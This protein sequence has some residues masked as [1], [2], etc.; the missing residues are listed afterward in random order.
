M[1]S[2]DEINNFYFNLLRNKQKSI[3]SFLNLTNN[4]Y[5]KILDLITK[6]NMQSIFLEF[7]KENDCTNIYK[8]DTISILQNQSKLLTIRNM[9]LISLGRK[10]ADLMNKKSINYAFLKGFRLTKVYPSKSIRTIRDLDILVD[11]DQIDMATKAL[12][13][14]GLKFHKDREFIS[15]MEYL[16]EFYDIPPLYDH[17]GNAIEIHYKIQNEEKSTKCKFAERILSS[18]EMVNFNEVKISCS[19]L[20]MTYAHILYQTF[21]KDWISTGHFFIYDLE[22]IEQQREFSR[23]KTIKL[24]DE[25]GLNKEFQLY[26]DL[27]KLYCSN[28]AKFLRPITPS[29]VI[30]DAMV[31][32]LNTGKFNTEK[33]NKITSF[34]SLNKIK[35]VIFPKRVRL[36]REFIF[37]ITFFNYFFIFF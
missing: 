31:L 10:I 23:Q 29:S 20:E 15:N 6:S 7:L 34:W 17:H 24:I 22:L 13:D 1:N 27:K 35:E 21:S 33:M 30:D 18:K 32:L 2:K 28:D 9:Q 36:Q 12:N 26:E 19:N 8:N 16:E 4:D 3:E 25:L 11:I 37:K 5:Q 14:A